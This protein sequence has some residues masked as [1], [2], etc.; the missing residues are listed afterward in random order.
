[1]EQ[2]MNGK[3]HHEKVEES[4]FG[5]ADLTCKTC[6]VT[7]RFGC[8]LQTEKIRDFWGSLNILKYFEIFWKTSEKSLQLLGYLKMRVMFSDLQILPLGS[9]VDDSFFFPA[10]K[11]AWNSIWR[12]LIIIEIWKNLEKWMIRIWQ[13]TLKAVLPPVGHVQTC[14]KLRA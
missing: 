13:K 2:H 1:M 5:P 11:K 3:K 10:L 9:T 7:P 8:S 12:V 6:N 14:P 4:Q